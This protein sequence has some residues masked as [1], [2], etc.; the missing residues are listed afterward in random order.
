MAQECTADP[1]SAMSF[2]CVDGGKE[3]ASG[4]SPPRSCGCRIVSHYRLV[5]AGGSK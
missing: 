2:S 3:G 4:V 1:S 5:V